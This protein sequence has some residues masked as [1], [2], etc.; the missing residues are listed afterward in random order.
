M[1]KLQKISSLQQYSLSK[2]SLNQLRGGR[3]YDTGGKNVETTPGNNCA[4]DTKTTWDEAD[5][6][7]WYE[8]C[9]MQCYC[10]PT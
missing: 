7:T 9:E 5:G 4:T 6:S 8:Y 3:G 10:P 1:R 2:N